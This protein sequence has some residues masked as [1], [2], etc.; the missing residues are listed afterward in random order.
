MMKTNLIKSVIKSWKEIFMNSIGIFM[1]DISV[2]PL[3]TDDIQGLWSIVIIITLKSFIT[4]DE[5][6]NKLFKHIFSWLTHVITTVPPRYVAILW[7]RLYFGDQATMIHWKRNLH[8]NYVHVKFDR[9]K[10]E[11]RIKDRQYNK[12]HCILLFFNL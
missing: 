2:S 3:K 12:I 9:D 11:S 5:N 1:G 6:L 10:W 4:F 8:I 7:T